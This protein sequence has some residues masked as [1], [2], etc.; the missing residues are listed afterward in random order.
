VAASWRLEQNRWLACRDGVE[1]ELLDPHTGER[2]STR[3]RLRQLIG[4]LHATASELGAAPA[5]ERAASMV[6]RNGAI[7]QR[8]AAHVDGARAVAQS[9]AERFLERWSG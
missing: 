8:E 1:G 9:L 3:E 7:A 4:E 6:E 2:A 5:L